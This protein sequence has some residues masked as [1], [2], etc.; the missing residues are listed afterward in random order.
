MIDLAVLASRREYLKLD[1]WLSDKMLEHRE[2][3][4]Q[5]CVSFLKRRCPSILGRWYLFPLLDV[6]RKTN[7]VQ[8]S[9]FFT[10]SCPVK[11]GFVKSLFS[12]NSN[13]MYLN[14]Y[15]SSC[16]EQETKSSVYESNCLLP[17]CLLHA[18]FTVNAIQKAK[19][20]DYHCLL[21]GLTGNRTRVYVSVACA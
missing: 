1:K 16:F 13:R 5:A 9:V 18:P 20:C 4:I 21:S 14:L 11:T 6:H 7:R 17:I 15:S 3:F 10:S 8:K 2:E 12:R 19:S